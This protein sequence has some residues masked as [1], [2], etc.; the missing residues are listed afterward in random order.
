MSCE[1]PKVAEYLSLGPSLV[2]QGL[3]LCDPSAGAR[4]R[5]LL[6]ELDPACCHC[7]FCIL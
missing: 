7:G 4:L 6:R 5:S 1:N 3:R 2:V